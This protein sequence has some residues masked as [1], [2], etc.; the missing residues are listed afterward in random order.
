MT[1]HQRSGEYLSNKHSLVFV[2]RY[3]QKA[4]IVNIWLRCVNPT[5][6]A[7]AGADTQLVRGLFYYAAHA[8]SPLNISGSCAAGK[9]PQPTVRNRFLQACVLLYNI[10]ICGGFTAAAVLVSQNRWNWL[11]K[12]KKKTACVCAELDKYCGAFCHLQWIKRW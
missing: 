5:S 9:D 2:N 10:I 3:V 12:C 8:E 1:Q 4:V 7:T 11:K 6:G